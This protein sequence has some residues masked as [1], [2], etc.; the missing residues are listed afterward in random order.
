MKYTL[1]MGIF[2][3]A[4]FF[5]WLLLT[6]TMPKMDVQTPGFEEQVVKKLHLLSPVNPVEVG[7]ELTDTIVYTF[8]AATLENWSFFDFSRG[9]VVSDVE[10]FKDAELWDLA[11]RRGKIAS[12]GGGTNKNGI[13]EVASLK[14]TDFDS[15]TSVPEGAKYSKDT[16]TSAGAD[17]KNVNLDN[18]YSYNFMDH[19]LKSY[20]KVLIIKTAEGNYA[21]MQLISYYCEKD[22][23]KLTG[24]YTIKYVY[25]GDGSKSFVKNVSE[26]Q[27]PQVKKTG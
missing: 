6:F 24:C 8:D 26:P 18:W 23:K 14:T 7:S 5:L 12:N 21:K 9:S 17:P 22:E 11:F 25:Q 15:V 10:N 27:A 20:K 16:R 1:Y 4:I 19:N 13:V 3:L 2:V